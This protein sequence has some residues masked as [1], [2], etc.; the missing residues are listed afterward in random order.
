MQN[1]LNVKLKKGLTCP[2]IEYHAFVKRLARWLEKDA[3]ALKSGIAQTS[4][5]VALTRLQLVVEADQACR[6]ARLNKDG[7]IRVGSGMGG[8]EILKS[9][10][11]WSKDAR[12]MVE[13]RTVEITKAKDT[14]AL[15]RS[16]LGLSRV[17]HET[18]STVTLPEVVDSL[19][20]LVKIDAVHNQEVVKLAGQSLG[21]TGRGHFVHLADDGSIVIPHDWT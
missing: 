5:E 8:N 13:E 9:I 18:K 7:S 17:Y 11:R 6:R 20:R 1:G 4:N 14:V 2:S 15:A 3:E 21:I 16:Q 10:S 12:E 19:L